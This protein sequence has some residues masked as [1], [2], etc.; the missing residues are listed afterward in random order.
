M[1]LV[2]LSG[3]GSYYPP[4]WGSILVSSWF[5]V[6]SYL[7]F[8]KNMEKFVL[9]F[10]FSPRCGFRGILILHKHNSTIDRPRGLKYTYCMPIIH[11]TQTW[12]RLLPPFS[13]G[14]R[15]NVMLCIAIYFFLSA[16]SFCLNHYTV[17][18]PLVFSSSRFL[19][20]FHATSHLAGTGTNTWMLRVFKGILLVVAAV[21]AE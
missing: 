3:S 13:T 21:M 1:L 17:E 9:V 10:P 4:L 2:L 20:I 11:G 16:P 14:A 12:I 8:Q 18:P 7:F 5:E 15:H 6:Y 19:K